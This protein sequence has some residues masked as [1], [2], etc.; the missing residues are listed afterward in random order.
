MTG[1]LKFPSYRVRLNGARFK[2]L[3]SRLM[4]NVVKVIEKVVEVIEYVRGRQ[5][6]QGWYPHIYIKQIH[7]EGFLEY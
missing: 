1:R 6:V 3:K 5:E 7:F 4:L 2:T